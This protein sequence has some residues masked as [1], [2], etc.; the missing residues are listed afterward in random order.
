[1]YGSPAFSVLS[2]SSSNEARVRGRIIRREKVDGG[3]H[4]R[5]FGANSSENAI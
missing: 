3:C 1:M 5:E 2:H 4:A